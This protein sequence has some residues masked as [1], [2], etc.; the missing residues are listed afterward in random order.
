MPRPFDSV[1]TTEE[2]LREVVPAP[3][4]SGAWDKSLSFIEEHSAAFIAKCPFVLV[5][6]SDT[7]GRMD[8][9]PKGD[10]P[11]FVRVLDE[12]T[13]AI[14][15][16]PGNGRADSFRNIIENPRIG[17]YFLVPGRQET[18]RINGG[19][20]LVRDQWLLD[21]MAVKGKPAQLAL[22][23]DVEEVFFHCAK[24]IVRSNLWDADEWID[25]S[26]LASMGQVM[27]DQIKLDVPAEAIDRGLQKDIETRLY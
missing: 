24:C 10:P 23:V 19:A 2:M 27:R 15:D 21:E 4:N 1:I 14:P 16:R 3:R 20:R 18:L 7:S 22:V 12:K 17:L 11:G 9:S 25:A 13:I 8:V 26:G 5:A 6:T